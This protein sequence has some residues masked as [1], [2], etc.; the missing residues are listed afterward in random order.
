MVA[1]AARPFVRRIFWG[2]LRWILLVLIPFSV[3]FVETWLNTQ[4]IKRDYRDYELKAQMK[5]LSQSLDSLRIKQATLEK[6]D[7]MEVEAPDLGLVAPGPNQIRE[8]HCKAHFGAPDT[9][10]LTTFDMARSGERGADVEAPGSSSDESAIGR[11]GESCNS[12][13][14]FQTGYT[15]VMAPLRKA[16]T[17]VYDSYFGRS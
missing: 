6:M 15:K 1:D 10:V 13:R 14:H 9:S 4:T 17:G 2:R 3:M 16:L 12:T 8:I 11:E 5:T 7:R